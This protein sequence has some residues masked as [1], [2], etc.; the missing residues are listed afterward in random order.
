MRICL[1]SAC[2]GDHVPGHE[3]ADPDC[4]DIPGLTDR[5]DVKAFFEKE[6]YGP[7]ADEN[8][9]MYLVAEDDED[10]IPDGFPV[11]RLTA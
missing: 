6:G 9:L 2:P 7:D 10:E 1:V 8:V 5:D 11:L 4:P 3:L